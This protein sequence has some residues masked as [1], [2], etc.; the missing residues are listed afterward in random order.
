MAFFWVFWLLFCVLCAGGVLALLA[1]LLHTRLGF[2]WCGAVLGFDS[3]V[4]VDREGQTSWAG[5]SLSPCY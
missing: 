2:L 1:S 4:F 3:V 5:P